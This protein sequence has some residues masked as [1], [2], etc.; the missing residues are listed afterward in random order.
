MLEQYQRVLVA[1]GAGFI[2]S[3]IVDKLLEADVDVTVLDNLS[4][5][6]MENLRHLKHNI[7]F[8]FVKGDIRNVTQ[9]KA[10][11][12]N[13]DAV[14]NDAAVVS[15]R[16]SVENPMLVNEVN[17]NGALNLLKASVDSGVKRFIQAS[18]ASI[19]GDTKTLPVTED[20]PPKPI[21]PYAVSELAAENY[22]RA[23]HHVYGLETISL[24]YF[25]VYGPRQSRNEYS[26]V[27]TIFINRLLNNQPLIIF[28]DG[29]QTRDFVY[30]EDVAEANILALAR[31]KASGE[32]FNIATCTPTSIN[33][34]AETLMRITGKKAQGPLHKKPKPGEIKH[35]YARI[36][37]A[38]RI[39]GYKPMFN[40]DKGLRQLVEWYTSKPK[41]PSQRL[42]KS[43]KCLNHP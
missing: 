23:F 26:G 3:H 9:V 10:A 38:E 4:T 28:G 20:M 2:G 13:S 36:G 35:S 18:S 1:G 19:Y 43:G 7:N 12:K 39:L 8:H 33:K 6:R 17:V 40:I 41:E 29:E 24:R 15:V 11:V 30:V 21:S 25:N 37:K 16:L 22:A 5:G 14:F 31:N 27:I 32:V 34:L 42:R